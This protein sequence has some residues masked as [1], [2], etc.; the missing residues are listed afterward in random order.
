MWRSGVEGV[1][2]LTGHAFL[3]VSDDVTDADVN[4]LGVDGLGG[5]SAPRAVVAI[6][7]DGE[8]GGLDVLL[9]RR[10]TGPGPENSLVARPDLANH[11]RARFAARIRHDVQVLGHPQGDEVVVALA[12]GVGGLTEVGLEVRTPG[13]GGGLSAVRAALAAVPAGTPMLAACSPGNARAVR[14]FLAA[15]FAPLG[16]VQ[17]WRPERSS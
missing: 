5:A 2:A 12:R 17:L 7:G 1:V 10:A 8:M 6:A 3:A 14:T 15:G 11:A 16:E 9:G 13:R 4:R